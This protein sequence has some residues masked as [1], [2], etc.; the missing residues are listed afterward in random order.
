MT[1]IGRC[2]D[3]LYETCVSAIYQALSA[4]VVKHLQLPCEGINVDSINIHVD[5][6]YEPDGDSKAN[7]ATHNNL[8]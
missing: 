2:F 1:P 3:K 5:G 7:D 8:K 4:S 6:S